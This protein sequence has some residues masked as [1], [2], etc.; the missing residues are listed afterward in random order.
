MILS[1]S[2]KILSRRCYFNMA[3]PIGLSTIA[4]NM[5]KTEFLPSFIH[6]CFLILSFLNRKNGQCN[7]YYNGSQILKCQMSKTFTSFIS[8]FQTH[9]PK[10]LDM[11]RL[12]LRI[13]DRLAGDW[14]CLSVNPAVDGCPFRIREEWGSK[15]TEIAGSAFHFFLS[16]IH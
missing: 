12:R 9:N 6:A 7:T 1:S 11:L 8:L 2:R 3:A 4:S 15:K 14:K 10:R 13:R 5:E 16:M